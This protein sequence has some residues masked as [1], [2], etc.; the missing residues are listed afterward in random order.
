MII[1]IFS[2]IEFGWKRHV[3]IPAIPTI[4]FFEPDKRVTYERENLNTV[5]VVLEFENKIQ[6][7]SWNCNVFI[8][9][10]YKKF[11]LKFWLSFKF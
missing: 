1:I 5:I 9:V 2:M 4:K 11:G 6:I 3:Y 7:V 10:H 8:E